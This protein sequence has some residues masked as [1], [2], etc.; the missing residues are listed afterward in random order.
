MFFSIK[1][2][3]ILIIDWPLIWYDVFFPLLFSIVQYIFAPV[4]VFLALRSLFGNF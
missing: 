1:E 4:F 3:T 2:P